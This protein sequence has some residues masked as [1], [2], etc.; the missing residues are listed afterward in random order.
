YHLALTYSH[1]AELVGENQNFYRALHFFRLATKREEENDLILVDLAVTLINIAQNSG[2]TTEIASCYQEAE[3]KL[4]LA[5]RAGNLQSYYQLAGLY[6]L[7][8]D[9]D[10]SIAF[11]KKAYCFNALPSVDEILE[12]EWLDYTRSSDS[13]KEFLLGLERKTSLQEEM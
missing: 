6:S 12:D 3:N 10:Q 4:I 11:L 5:A 8:N 1:L 9:S 2:D 7:L 13:F